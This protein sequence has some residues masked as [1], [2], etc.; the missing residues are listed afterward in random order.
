[1]YPRFSLILLWLEGGDRA[2]FWVL[3]SCVHLLTAGITT[4][5]TMSAVSVLE[6]K[7]RLVH[8]RQDLNQLSYTPAPKLHD[9]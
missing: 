3:I 9:L 2:E 7:P 5:P 1:M 4:Q 8:T 6:M